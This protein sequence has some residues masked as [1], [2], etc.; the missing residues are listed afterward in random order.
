MSIRSP[1][2]F[3][4]SPEKKPG[5]SRPVGAV[6]MGSPT[7]ELCAA[8]F[9]R[10]IVLALCS[11]TLAVSSV[12]GASLVGRIDGEDYVS[13]TAQFRI[14]APVLPELGGVITDTDNVVTFQDN[15]GTHVSV[16]C[17]PLDA[18]QRW[19]FETRGRRDYL[20]F[21]LTDTVM[22]NFLARFPGSTIESARYLP[23]LEGGAL[24]GYTL[25]PGGSQ[26]ENL[27]RVMTGPAHDPVVAKRGSLLF[28]HNRH[29]YVISLEL[30]ERATQ[31]SSYRQTVEQENDLLFTR[32]TALYGRLTFSDGRP[33]TP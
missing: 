2:P 26:F 10:G 3:Q 17:F 22:P 13:P 14:R 9:P 15:F 4:R 33:R 19:E 27:N 29:V 31:R 5:E 11:F 1:Y 8:S 24:L 28:I 6:V 7:G 12:A 30:A 25:L 16:A 32:L 23:E 20:L 21:F 18:L